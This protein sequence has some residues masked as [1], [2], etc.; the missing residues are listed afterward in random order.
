MLNVSF[1]YEISEFRGAL[2]T[3]FYKEPTC[4]GLS[5]P[6]TCLIKPKFLRNSSVMSIFVTI[7]SLDKHTLSRGNDILLPSC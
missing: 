4:E 3:Y 2:Y 6:E 5:V 7:G 1:S